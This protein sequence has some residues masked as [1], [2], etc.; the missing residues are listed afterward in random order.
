MSSHKGEL[1]YCEVCGTEVIVEKGGDGTLNCCSQKM[2]H[3]VT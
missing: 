3:K 2:K 1:Y